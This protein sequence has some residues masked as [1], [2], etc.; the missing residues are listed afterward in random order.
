[1]SQIK[2]KESEHAALFPQWESAK[3]KET[4]EKRKLDEANARLQTLYS[5][6]GRATHYRTKAERD[7][8]LNKEIASM[9]SYKTSQTSTLAG[10]RTELS[11]VQRSLSEITQ[12][13]S[14]TQSKIEEGRARVGE[15]ANEISRLNIQKNEYIEQRKDNWREDSKNEALLGRAAD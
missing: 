8:F 11:T 9:D 7:Q 12:K 1:E 6:Q 2:S 15:I 4:T 5:K 13:I 14:N 3:E 10:T